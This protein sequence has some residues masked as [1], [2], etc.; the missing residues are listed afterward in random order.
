LER[1][2]KRRR[3]TVPDRDERLVVSPHHP[4]SAY[5]LTDAEKII[6]QLDG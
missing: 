2:L 3:I 6:S 4:R 5:A 1:R